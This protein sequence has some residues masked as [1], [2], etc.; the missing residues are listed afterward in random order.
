MLQGSCPAPMVCKCAQSRL[1]LTSWTVACQAPL[2]MEF[3]R[4][5]YWNGL[6]F[7]PPG[8]LPDSGIEPVCPTLAGR[9]FTTQPPGV[10]TD[11]LGSHW[12]PKY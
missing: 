1:I 9:F 8:D 3:S 10:P 12:F 5:E 11:F 2:S 4:Q 7:P 6:P